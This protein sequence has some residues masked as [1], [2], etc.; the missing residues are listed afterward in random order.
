MRLRPLLTTAFVTAFL[1]AAPV[2]ARAEVGVSIQVTVAGVALGGIAWALSV[3]WS[4]D[5]LPLLSVPLAPLAD[6]SPPPL[7]YL[8]L[9]VLPLP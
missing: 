3:G 2:G 6:E 5:L 7:L 8:P 4:S 9:F 1:S